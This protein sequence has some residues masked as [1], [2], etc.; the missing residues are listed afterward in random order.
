MDSSE[1]TTST[2]MC[3]LKLSLDRGYRGRGVREAKLQRFVTSV[4]SMVKLKLETHSYK[5]K[6]NEDVTEYIY[7]KL[8]RCN[9]ARMGDHII[10]EWT[11]DRLNNTRIREYLG[12]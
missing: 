7:E 2:R 6:T 4:R 11:V 9:N 1:G 12:P 5:Q 8:S 3:D 10:I